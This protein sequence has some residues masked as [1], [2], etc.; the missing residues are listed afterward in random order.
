MH[1]HGCLENSPLAAENS[2]M[3]KLG[4]IPIFPEIDYCHYEFIIE[5]NPNLGPLIFLIG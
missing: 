4:K 2:I 3:F 5:W 1:P